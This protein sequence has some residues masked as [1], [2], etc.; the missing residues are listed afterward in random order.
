MSPAWYRRLRLRQLEL[1]LELS[2]QP[3]L[4]AAAQALH[5]TQPAVS[6]Q[7]ADIESALGMPLFERGRGLRPTLGGQAM[8]RYAEQVLAGARRVGEEV[9]AIR[10]GTA[11]VVRIGIMLVAATVLVPRTMSR[12]Q[13]Q[14]DGSRLRIVLVEDI[15]QGLWPRLER[16]EIDIVVG[17][18]DARVLSSELPFEELY[19]D[20]HC[21]VCGPRHALAA[22]RKPAWSD[23]TRFPW[24]LPP[25]QTALRAAVNTSFH[26]LGLPA[27]RSQIDSGSLAATQSILQLNECLALMSRTAAT[28]YQALGLLKALPLNLS[29]DVGPVGMAWFDAKP[30]AAVAR[31]LAALRAEGRM[32]AA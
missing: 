5:M 28:H 20:P 2:R 13:L 26:T 11:G 7:L 27:P 25:E 12:L 29:T 22:K 6:Q 15:M 32:L 16:G 8:L 17:R 1:L 30:G 23:V 14:A 31:V 9:Q 24:V 4:T 3:S 18:L 21:V 10:A 19:A